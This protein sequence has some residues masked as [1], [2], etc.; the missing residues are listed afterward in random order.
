[1]VASEHVQ[2]AFDLSRRIPQG[3]PAGRVCAELCFLS[4][5]RKLFLGRGGSVDRLFLQ[6]KM[7]LEERRE[8]KR[9]GNRDKC[10][11]PPLAFGLLS[12]QLVRRQDW[13]SDQLELD[14][15]PLLIAWVE[16]A[17]AGP[18][19]PANGLSLIC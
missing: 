4:D 13:R 2:S 7:F 3:G 6:G 18:L 12:W 9:N 10:S 15:V 16:E 19:L 14:Q 8:R 11:F 17:A 5:R 1:M